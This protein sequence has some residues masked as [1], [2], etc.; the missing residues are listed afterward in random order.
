MLT[1]GKKLFWNDW[2]NSGRDTKKLKKKWHQFKRLVQT[3][4]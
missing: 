3:Y 1:Y 2:S 4:N